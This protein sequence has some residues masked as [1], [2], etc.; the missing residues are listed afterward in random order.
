MIDSFT[1]VF[2]IDISAICSLTFHLKR[3]T[4]LCKT[5]RHRAPFKNER[6]SE[7]KLK[8]VF[9]LLLLALPC[10]GQGRGTTTD[11]LRVLTFNLYGRPNS[12]WA[13]RQTMILNVLSQN[14][15]DLIALQEVIEPGGGLDV[16]AR[17][18]ADSLFRR[19]GLTYN[20]VYQRTH[21]SWS[22][23][24]EGVAILSPHIILDSEARALPAG[25]FQR[26]VVW[27]RFLTPA[28]IVNFFDTHLSF[29]NQ[30]SVRQMQVAALRTFVDEKN[31]DSIAVAN[32]V[33]GDFN[34]IP[35][36]PPILQMTSPA[37]GARYID[38]W[39]RANPG[40]PG[41]TVPSN[42]P[43]ARIDYV[44]FRE[45]DA[46]EVLEAQIEFDQHDPNGL[47]PSDHLGVSSTLSTTIGKIDVTVLTPAAGMQVSGE[48]AVT[49]SLAAASEPVTSMLYLSRDAG[50]TWQLQWSGQSAD[51]TYTWN[52]LSTPDGAR[53]LVRVAVR[54]DSSFGMGQSGGLF[55][56]NNPGNAAPELELETPRGGEILRGVKTI[57]W[58]A[59][60][61]DGDPLLIAIDV[62]TD[63]GGSWQSLA[64]GLMNDGSFMW[65]TVESPNSPVYRLRLSASDGTVERAVT[66][67]I[68]SVENPR[69]VLGPSV[70][71]HLS[72]SGSGLVSGSI[73]DSTRLTGHR[74]QISFDDTSS[75]QKSYSVYDADAGVFVVESATE[76]DGSTE[77]PHFDG[78]RLTIFDLAR[79]EVDEANTGWTRGASTL[80]YQISTP[81]ILIG[82]QQIQSVPYPADY[83]L[84]LFDD[85]VDTTSTAF[86]FQAK[87]LRFVVRNTTENRRS[88]VFFNEFDNNQT[89]SHLDQIRILEPDEN[90]DPQI[91]WTI[92]FQGASNHVP[93]VSGDEFTLTTL[94]PFTG[95]DLFEFRGTLSTSVISPERG[96]LPIELRVFNNY[97]NPFNPETT[98]SYL[99][100][101][102]SRVK[103][104]IYNLAGQ[105]IT[106]LLDE[107]QRSGE[108]AVKWD[109]KNHS[110]LTVASGVYFYRIS[111]GISAVS[112]KMLL[113]K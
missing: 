34:A 24:F 27:C 50:A 75:R 61:A 36:S 39:Q 65:N 12:D 69:G 33:C 40:S 8:I 79:A 16:R 1:A 92:F 101:T 15:P 68:F 38:S 11:T 25:Q 89:I 41:F 9:G 37:D 51:N 74:Y 105:E 100:P 96:L 10:F 94:K 29:G 67:G 72:G 48:V 81:T 88:K 43:D 28:G 110:G 31:T 63:A 7:M 78:L 20:F 47:Y 55:T 54:G 58:Q 46:I 14:P 80:G 98:I 95:R 106:I 77:G 44:F 59:F 87:P 13:K 82:G 99:L 111:T 97:P 49:W 76:L 32:I 108:H 64:T 23:W 18:L 102:E 42:Q 6:V 52:T 22:Q 45:D 71:E 2:H 4:I 17:V 113:I 5:G 85:I 60:D 83:T 56:V 26:T 104:S 70:F 112:R 86:G 30:E 3:P 107:K 93:P 57:E 62:S 84:T 53:Y 66:S 109:G 90:G 73:V 21:F 19:T 35:E 91:G 103:L